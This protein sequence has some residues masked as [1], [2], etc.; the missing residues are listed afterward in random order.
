MSNLSQ[1]LMRKS[2]EKSISRML[3]EEL[4][5]EQISRITKISLEELK[6]FERGY[7]KGK[8]ESLVE[9]VSRMLDE[10]IPMEKI[11]KMSKLSMEELHEI[12]RETVWKRY[13]KNLDR[14]FSLSR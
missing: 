13:L 10:G 2:L 6:D 11:A 4:P 14:Q 3:E 8:R 5:L 12:R 9:I 1:G 7:K